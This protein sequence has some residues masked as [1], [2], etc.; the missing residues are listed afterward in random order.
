LKAKIVIASTLKPVIDPRAYE[1]MGKSLVATNLYEVHIIGSK[2]TIEEDSI[3][4]HPI[5]TFAKGKSH[6]I[7]LPWRIL[8][9][10]FRL[11]PTILI[12]NTHELL[13]IGVIYKFFKKAKVIYDIQEN[14]Y[15]NIIYQQNYRWIIRQ[16]L[17]QYIRIK[18][19]LL[20]GK[21]DHF[22]IAE[23]CYSDELN[24]IGNRFTIIENKFI[25]PA[26]WQKNK[27]QNK[28]SFLLSGTISKEYGVFEAIEFIKHFPVAEY[29]LVII[30]HCAN[31]QTYTTIK[32]LVKDLK[33]VDFLVQQTPVKHSEILAAVGNKT[34]GL[35][36]YQANKSTENKIPTKLYEYLGLGIPIIISFNKKWDDI[37]QKYKAGLSIDFQQPPNTE[38]ISIINTL[39]NSIQQIDLKDINWK[40]EETKLLASVNSLLK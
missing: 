18:E 4:L 25:A 24:F 11:R 8:K 16:V 23:K 27:D 33:N 29:Q 40:I 10:I 36:P 28:T 17:S 5:T 34:I 1:K 2:P 38:Q 32:S 6:R 31:K 26:K 14:Y 39:I 13:L 37:I 12:I 9:L 20:A 30:G 35:L 3:F 21:I 22:F 19:V 15:N 7:L